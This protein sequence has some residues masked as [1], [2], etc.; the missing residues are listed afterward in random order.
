MLY[1]YTAKNQKGEVYSGEYEAL[2]K[3]DVYGKVRDEGGKIL[4]VKEKRGSIMFSS[5]FS[6]IGSIKTHDK[7]IFAKNLSAMIG[8]GLSV[9]RALD[10][11]EKQTK[12]K[13]MMKLLHSLSQDVGKGMPFSQA[14]E[15]HPNV[16]PQIFVSMVLAGEESGNLSQS[17]MVIAIQMEKSYNL[18]KRIKGAM[19]YPAVIITLMLAIAILLL[20]YMV[21]TLTSTFKGLGVELPLST[22]IIIGA[23]DFM[24]HNT[25]VFLSILLGAIALITLFIK[26]S[27]G[28][29]I[30]DKTF[31]RL[32]VIGEIVKEVNSARTAR[33]MSSL[34]S[35]GVPIVNALEVT[36]AVV[37]NHLYKEAL[38]RARAGIQ[39]GETI[40][41][42]L[43]KYEKIYPAFIAE[44]TAVGEETG[45]ISE[46]LLNVATFYED[47][48]DDKTKNLSTIIEP[49]LMILIGLGVGIFAVS[50]IA[51]TY[52]LVN[53][54]N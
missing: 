6:F 27:F 5:L 14:L 9:T 25:V 17:L 52:S 32:P 13:A 23:S 18:S 45:K 44:M 35:S 48:V 8:A 22:R 19:I 30:L 28:K 1:T 11:M 34:L 4:S 33:T 39:K 50:M 38:A 21:P 40:S 2:S 7:I 29:R 31:I 54:I 20:I 43:S 53:V 12:D 15:R 49:A 37:P 46:M 41:S 42:V 51:P 36:E 47:D 24:V 10:V 3:L 16:F 26:S